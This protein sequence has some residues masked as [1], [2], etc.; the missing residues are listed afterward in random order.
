MALFGSRK[1]GPH[2]MAGFAG[3]MKD[4]V[5][6]LARSLEGRI[7]L[8][9]E[10][11]SLQKEADTWSV[12]R[13]SEES[14]EFDRVVV[15]TE[16]FHAAQLLKSLVPEESEKFLREIFYQDVAV[17]NCIWERPEDFETGLGCLVPTRFQQKLLGSL[18]PSE[19]FEGRAGE[20][21]LVTAQY[22][23][24]Q[25]I[26]EDPL[27]E[28]GFL[29]N[30]LGVG[31]QIPLYSSFRVFPKALP[32]Y[33]LGHRQQAEKLISDLPAGLSLV[34]NYLGGIGLSA[35]IRSACELDC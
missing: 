34:G 6:S 33:Q 32:Q 21:K 14:L 27:S 10:V 20:T 22:F 12:L 28:L 1:K 8:G 35:I 4:L 30:L 16:S 15:A 9:S 24:G 25:G 18:W 26:P 23:S 3:G 29:Q 11:L 2:G 5:E 19:F 13:K 17:W 31:D 7:H